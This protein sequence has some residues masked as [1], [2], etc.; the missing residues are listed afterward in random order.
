MVTTTINLIRQGHK[1]QECFRRT[2]FED[3][4]P[5]KFMWRRKK[6]WKLDSPKDEVA[7]HLLSGNT[8]CF[9]DM[10]GDIKE[11][12]PNRTDHL[13]HCG[14][15]SISLNGMPE[16]GRNHTNHDGEAGEIPTERRSQSHRERNMKL[17]S[18][19]TV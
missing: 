18:N 5:L 6:N 12:W 3:E 11:G 17:S 8:D 14:G 13:G 16:Q 9:W 1:A 4:E 7:D 19:A 10:I 2:S 15:A